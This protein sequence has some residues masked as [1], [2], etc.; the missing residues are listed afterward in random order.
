MGEFK[1]F[2]LNKYRLLPMFE[3]KCERLFVGDNNLKGMPK[4]TKWAR[5]YRREDDIKPPC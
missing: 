1:H 3:K 5:L 4:G 2:E